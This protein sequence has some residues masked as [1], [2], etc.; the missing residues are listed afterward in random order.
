MIL[1]NDLTQAEQLIMIRSTA[2]N[3]PP[4]NELTPVSLLMRHIVSQSQRL[5]LSG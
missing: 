2:G 4:V 1:E 5:L 3:G